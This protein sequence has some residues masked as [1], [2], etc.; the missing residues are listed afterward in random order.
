MSDTPVKQNFDGQERAMCYIVTTAAVTSH[1]EI[2]LMISTTPT[3][4][5][6]QNSSNVFWQ[7]SM[8]WYTPQVR[9]HLRKS[10]K[11]VSYIFVFL[12]TMKQ[13]KNVFYMW[14]NKCEL[15]SMF[16]DVGSLFFSFTLLHNSETEEMSSRDMGKMCWS[17]SV[18]ALKK[19]VYFPLLILSHWG[20]GVCCSSC[21]WMDHAADPKEW[22]QTISVGIKKQSTTWIDRSKNQ[23][24]VGKCSI[25]KLCFS[26]ASSFDAT[27]LKN[28]KIWEN[29]PNQMNF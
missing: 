14:L 21:E 11:A 2:V 19:H 4:L 15:R 1:W 24:N 7:L 27:L 20:Q 8:W 13:K 5:L 29:K 12:T 3:L 22:K 25:G 10:E 9:L 26:D 6:D 16:F 17:A 23:E 18:A 28:E